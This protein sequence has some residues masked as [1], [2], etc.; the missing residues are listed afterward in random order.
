MDIVVTGTVVKVLPL[1][2]G[3]SQRTGAPWQR[4]TVIVEH[5]SGQYP[6]TIAIDISGGERIN[7]MAM[8][9]G[10]QVTCHLNVNTREY[11]GKFINSI[12]CWKVE[13]PGQVQQQYAQQPAP[14]QPAPQQG[15]YQPQPGNG[16]YY[17]N[18]PQ[19]Q[20]QSAQQQGGANGDLPF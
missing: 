13:H 10:Q 5:E 6:R 9:V 11:N 20:G 2:E 15:G 1:V 3:V 12:E 17:Q 18:P 14:Q 19:P 4:Q 8:T 16:V 7:A